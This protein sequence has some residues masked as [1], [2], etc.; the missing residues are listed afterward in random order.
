MN[1]PIYYTV[2]EQTIE[3]E[4]FG[5]ERPRVTKHG[6]FMPPEYT[7]KK[8]ALQWMFPRFDAPDLVRMTVIAV[9]PMPSSWSK[10]KREKMYGRHAKPKPDTDNIAGAVMD[11]LFPDDDDMVAEVAVKKIWG[12][13]AALHI[14]IE[15]ITYE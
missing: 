10:K 7:A 2:A 9:R 1:Q 3:L 4:P 15:G 13:E 8:Q 12:E 11:S 14:K 6:V 5:K